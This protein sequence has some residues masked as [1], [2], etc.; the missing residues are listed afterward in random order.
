VTKALIQ[1]NR[2]QIRSAIGIITGHGAFRKHLQHMGLFHD[3]P[4]CRLCGQFEETAKHTLLEYESLER[5]R[6]CLFGGLYPSG[7]ECPN[8]VGKVLELITGIELE[9]Q[10]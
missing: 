3:D 5:R 8:F 4:I 6:T 10:S 7:D 2:R 1:R 9:L